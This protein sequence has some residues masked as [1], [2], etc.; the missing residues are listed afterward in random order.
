MDLRMQSYTNANK[1][2]IWDFCINEVTGSLVVTENSI[3][4]EHQQAVV[5]TF[6]QR[7]SIPQL[8]QIGV[9]WAEFLSQSISTSELNTQIVNAIQENAKSFAYLPVY[10]KTNGKLQVTIKEVGSA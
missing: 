5:A 2:P 7:G 3:A 9:Q 4:E 6:T 8:P 1:E 10:S